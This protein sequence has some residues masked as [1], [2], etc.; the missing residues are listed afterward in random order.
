MSKVTNA[1]SMCY[2]WTLPI[3]P[4]LDTSNCTNM[5]GMFGSFDCAVT[6]LEGI[7]CRGVFSS[8]AND[9]I[10]T[11]SSSNSI[12]YMVLKNLGFTSTTT[13]YDLRTFKKWGI[14]TDDNPDAR[15]SLVDS[16]ITYSVDRTGMSTATIKLYSSVKA[17]L[18][19]D[20]IA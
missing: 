17:L 15:Q 18:T 20:E 12:S 2:G 5:S 19:E 8:W 14:A 16:L 13:S 10:I 4:E 7:D 11:T 1:D 3:V 9:N 6:R